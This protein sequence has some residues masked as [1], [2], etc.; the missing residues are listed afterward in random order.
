MYAFQQSGRKVGME[1]RFSISC[2]PSVLLFF[3]LII[4]I[5]QFYRFQWWLHAA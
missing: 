4:I 3:F 1:V 2:L 5:I